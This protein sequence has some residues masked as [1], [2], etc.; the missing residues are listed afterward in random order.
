MVVSTGMTLSFTIQMAKE[1][2]ELDLVI[3]GHSHSFLWTRNRLPSV[4]K[5]EGK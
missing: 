3:G 2:D 4:E 1:V 5:P